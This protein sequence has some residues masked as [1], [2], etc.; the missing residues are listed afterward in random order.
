[1][2]VQ[3]QFDIN[4]KFIKFSPDVTTILSLLTMSLDILH[5]N[6]FRISEK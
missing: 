5:S 4:D 1:M 3:I 6:L 2:S